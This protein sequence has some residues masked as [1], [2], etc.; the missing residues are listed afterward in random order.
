MSLLTERVSDR[1]SPF[2]ENEIAKK[3]E[4]VPECQ[5]NSGVSCELK[6]RKCS[7]CGF[8]PIVSELRIQAIKLGDTHFLRFTDRYYAGT[9][10]TEYDSVQTL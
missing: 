6:G 4:K 9:K 3:Y 7:N 8:N 10:G 5:Y 1:Y 2:E